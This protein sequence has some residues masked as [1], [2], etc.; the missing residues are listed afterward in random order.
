MISFY[1]S[2]GC[3]VLISMMGSLNAQN[4]VPNG[5]FEEFF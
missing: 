1:R 4:L 3:V 5:S 2:V